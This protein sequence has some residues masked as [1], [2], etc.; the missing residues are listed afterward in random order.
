MTRPSTTPAT[1]SLRKCIPWYIRAIPTATGTVPTTTTAATLAHT[2]RV[3][4]NTITTTARYTVA[5]ATC[6]EGK[7]E[8]TGESSRRG[9]SGRDRP[10][11]WVTTMNAEASNTRL[12]VMSR[13][14]VHRLHRTT[15]ATTRTTDT[16]T[17]VDVPD[18][19]AAQ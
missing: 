13:A 17:L 18:M 6:P 12:M 1:T 2:A 14:S 7:L 19:N 5:A 11:S 15:T 8:S 10:T 9:T 4:R 3:W 16:T